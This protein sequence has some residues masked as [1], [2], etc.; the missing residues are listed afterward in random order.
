MGVR[1]VLQ[2]NMLHRFGVTVAHAV[3]V[4]ADADEEEDENH[5]RQ[6]HPDVRTF[7]SSQHFIDHLLTIG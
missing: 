7:Q 4:Y 1:I 3:E 6:A 2:G 5:E